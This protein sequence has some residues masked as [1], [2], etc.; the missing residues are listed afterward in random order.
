MPHLGEVQARFKDKVTII[1]VSDEPLPK[2]VEFLASTNAATG[3]TWFDGVGFRMATDPDGSVKE[4]YFKAA[5]QRGIPSAFIVGKTGEIEWIG[6]PMGMD[7]PLAKIV[8]GTW[9][10]EAYKKQREQNMALQREMQQIRARIAEAMAEGNHDKA[11]EVLEDVMTR[12]P[13]NAGLLMQKWNLL[14]LDMGRHEEAYRL[15]ARIAEDNWSNANLLNALAWT[16]VDDKRVKVRDLGLAM[17]M[18]VRANELTHSKNAAILD[19]LARVHYEKGDLQTAI[20]WQRLAV[21][22]APANKMGEEI[23]AVLKKY[24]SEVKRESY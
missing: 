2:I 5:G 13:G 21:E 24:E 14:L 1:S 9:D 20:K 17:K 4:S 3:K 18:A 6:H 11:L 23:R 7:D 15:G 10:R 22:H 8:A 19:T 16:I 12:Y